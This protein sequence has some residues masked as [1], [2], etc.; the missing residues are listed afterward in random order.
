MSIRKLAL[1][2]MGLVA[3]VPIAVVL[4]LNSIVQV[5]GPY[6]WLATMLMLFIVQRLESRSR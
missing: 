4:D 3:M 6:C 1:C 2:A 5:I